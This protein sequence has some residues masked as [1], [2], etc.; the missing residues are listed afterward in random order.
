MYLTW[1]R[2]LVK[3]RIEIYATATDGSEAVLFRTAISAINPLAA[4][5][6]ARRLL[7]AR[8]K[9]RVARVLNAQG[10]VIYEVD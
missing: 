3:F 9:A 5:T 6:E 4:R 10:E 1:T 8:R 7:K 2:R